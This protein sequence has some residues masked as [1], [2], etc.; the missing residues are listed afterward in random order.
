MPAD[1]AV[2]KEHG[3]HQEHAL[4]RLSPQA[5]AKR[6]QRQRGDWQRGRDFMLE[7][8]ENW[9]HSHPLNAIREHPPHRPGAAGVRSVMR[10]DRGS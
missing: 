2:E 3:C 4:R 6:A 5:R 8:Y 1:R 7:V 9:E 10:P